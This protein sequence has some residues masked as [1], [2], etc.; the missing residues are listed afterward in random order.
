MG[1][2]HVKLPG[3]MT[4]I[5]CTRG[6]SKVKRCSCGRVGTLLCDWKVGNGK[7]CDV[8]ICEQ[9]AEH[10]AEDKDLCKEHSKAYAQWQ[11]KRALKT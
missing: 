4:A 2:E 1:C 3:G 10:V 9:C 5:V 8:P 11:I 7:T 6:R